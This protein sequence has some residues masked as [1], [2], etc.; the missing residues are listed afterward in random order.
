M[1]YLSCDLNE[2]A[3][4][5]TSGKHITDKDGIIHPS[6]T[7]PTFVLLLGCEGVCKIE[8]N[9]VEYSLEP[10]T[11][12][13]LFENHQHIGRIPCTLGQSHYWCHFTLR[14]PYSIVEGESAQSIASEINKGNFLSSNNLSESRRCS[15]VLIPEFI[16]IPSSEKFRILFH[17]LVDSSRS[18][19]IYRSSVCDL[20]LT[21]ILYELSGIS[22][23]TLEA[24]M[25]EKHRAL[26]SNV[27]E[28]IKRNSSD[29]TAVSQIADHFGYNPEYLTTLVKKSTG[30]SIIEHINRE[31]CKEAKRYLLSTSLTVSEIAEKCGF[32]DPKY[33]SRIFKRLTD[34]TPS[35]YRNA[36]FKIHTSR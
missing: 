30:L 34:T 23:S 26:I 33:F 5:S 25:D 18:S 4:Y 2:P 15:S 9:G 3:K 21:E 32:S 16:K 10:N 14:S 8:Q 22:V 6:R 31:R 36:Y 20:I 1:F 27:V 7:L 17:S 13:L 12:L 35:E 28:Y 11:A 24:S 29:I 19:S